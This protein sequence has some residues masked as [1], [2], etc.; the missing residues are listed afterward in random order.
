MDEVC[1]SHD[2]IGGDGVALT[3]G[4]LY[5]VL[6]IAFTVYGQLI[7]KQQVNTVGQFP[8]GA[9]AILFYLRFIFLR[10][11]VLSGFACAFMAALSWIGALSKFELSYIYPFMSLNF[12]LVVVLSVVFFREDVNLHKILGLA[13]ICVGVV[14]ASQ[15]STQ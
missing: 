5:L 11:L 7:I 15:G 10:P 2:Q 3:M 1:E 8:S 4:Y 12:V 13:L 14:I 6:T 9:A